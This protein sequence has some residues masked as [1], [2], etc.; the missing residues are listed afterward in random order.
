MKSE[1]ERAEAAKKARTE[2]DKLAKEQIQKGIAKNYVEALNQVKDTH[3][4]LAYTAIDGR[5]QKK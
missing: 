2:L 3:P 1:H 5:E 4:D